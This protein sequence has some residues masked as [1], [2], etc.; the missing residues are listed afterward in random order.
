LNL[1]GNNYFLGMTKTNGHWY[2]DDG[3]AVFVMRK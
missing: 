2:W 3:S 1:T